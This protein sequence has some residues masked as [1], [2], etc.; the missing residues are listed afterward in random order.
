M[1][2]VLP[3]A[4]TS[5]TWLLLKQQRAGKG[6]RGSPVTVAKQRPPSS[7][8]RQRGQRERMLE[9]DDDKKPP[10]LLRPTPTKKT[11]Q[12]NKALPS[13]STSSSS[14]KVIF[15][16]DTTEHSGDGAATSKPIKHEVDDKI[17]RSRIID[18][19]GIPQ[20][21]PTP[22]AHPCYYQGNIN[23]PV[24]GQ[25]ENLRRLWIHDR[26]R[27]EQ[28]GSQIIP[29]QQWT[30]PYFDP[31]LLAEPMQL[32]GN[33]LYPQQYDYT[34]SH[35]LP[36][37]T[38][39]HTVNRPVSSILQGLSTG[40]GPMNSEQLYEGLQQPMY[41]LSSQQ[42]DYGTQDWAGNVTAAEFLDEGTTYGET[43]SAG[44]VGHGMAFRR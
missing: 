35:G 5:I 30:Q 43:A 24:R 27:A 41:T 36:I 39:P 20:Y 15:M 17:A 37:N 11:R 42:G 16:S 18:L 32:A 44:F 33:V 38:D 21:A 23:F 3:D 14:N 2:D 26:Q 19:Q 25:T 8:A 4:N 13:P 34:S 10:K 28:Y 22:Q 9:S 29:Y 12:K 6:P 1:I 40:G 31:L 7:N